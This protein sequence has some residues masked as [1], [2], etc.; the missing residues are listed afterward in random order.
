M[1]L[2]QMQNMFST[3]SFYALM[4][5]MMAMP[6]LAS[7]SESNSDPAK[8]GTKSVTTNDTKSTGNKA[9][10]PRKVPV[11]INFRHNPNRYVFH[12]LAWVDEPYIAYRVIPDPYTGRYHKV[13]VLRYNRVLVRVYLDRMSNTYGYFDRFG[14]PVPYIPNR[15]QFRG[16]RF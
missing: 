12:F 3:L 9:A 6:N 4:L 10:S 1:K 13:R 8:A 16:I 15:Y 5:S 14:N 2:P 7:A 11:Q